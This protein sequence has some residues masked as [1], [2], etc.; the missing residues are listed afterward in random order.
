[1]GAVWKFG[2]P[3]VIALLLSFWPTTDR[4]DCIQALSIA[5]S[6]LNPGVLHLSPIDPDF[7]TL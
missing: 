4:K 7:N 5:T 1:M 3:V 6:R 2:W